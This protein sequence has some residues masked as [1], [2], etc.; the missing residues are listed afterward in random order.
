MKQ[1]LLYSEAQ[2]VSDDKDWIIF[3]H[4]AGGSTATWKCQLKQF[5]NHYNLLLIDLRDHGKSKNIPPDHTNYKFDIITEDIIQVIKKYQINKAHFITLSFGSVLLQ[6]L[7]IKYPNLVASAIFAGGIFKANIWIRSFVHVARFL[8]VILPYKWMYSI[9]SYLLMPR[10]RHQRSRK[11]YKKQA[12]KLTSSE[13]MKWVGLY[14]EFFS[15]LARFFNQKISFPALVVMG[16]EDYIFLKAAR[17]FVSN[18]KQVEL[19][20][21]RKAGHI[22]NIDKPDEFNRLSYD[23]INRKTYLVADLPT[24]KAQ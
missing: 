21:I 3:L 23:F 11:I 19:I 10:K 18:Q 13:Y 1:D 22:C 14:G 20:T 15:L 6:D 12:E 9:F 16:D 7:S 8:N 17:A 4:G 5:E 24:N 2:I